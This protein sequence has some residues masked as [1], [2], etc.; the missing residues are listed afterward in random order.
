MASASRWEIRTD[1][2]TLLIDL[3]LT[4]RYSLLHLIEISELI[5]VLIVQ[6]DLHRFMCISFAGT[7]QL[8]KEG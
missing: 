3:V 4:D 5:V 2:S 8:C 1:K 7:A 6:Y